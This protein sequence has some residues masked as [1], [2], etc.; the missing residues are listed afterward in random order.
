MADNDRPFLYVYSFAQLET[1]DLPVTSPAVTQS[2][3]SRAVYE[4]DNF[5]DLV[6]L[7]AEEVL[8]FQAELYDEEMNEA[9]YELINE[10]RDLHEATLTGGQHRRR[11]GPAGTLSTP[12]H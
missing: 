4:L 6:D 10:A 1:I 12:G 5:S 3:F 9:L 2:P 11:A 8:A 7:E